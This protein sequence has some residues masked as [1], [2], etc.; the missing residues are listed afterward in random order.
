MGAVPLGRSD[1]S[2]LQSSRVAR[3]ATS[4]RSA[5][6]ASS[7]EIAANGDVVPAVLVQEE[8]DI[9]GCHTLTRHGLPGWLRRLCSITDI[10]MI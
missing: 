7:S 8:L 9:P 5:K 10:G 1:V 6:S 3:L 2:Q 4:P